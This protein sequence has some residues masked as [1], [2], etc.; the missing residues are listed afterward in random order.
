MLGTIVNSI[1]IILGSLLGIIIKRGIK[2]QYKKIIMDGVGLTVIIIGIMGGVK[3][4]NIIL[5]IISI[6]LGSIIGEIIGIENKLNSL[7]N[8]LE[9]KFGKNDSNF[10]KGFV[11]AS[12]VYCVGAM[13]I[14]GS[15][16]SGLLGNHNT[17]FAKSVLD[18]ISS[19]IFAST[20]GI[21][22][23]FSSIAVFIYQGLITLLA[24]YLKDLLTSEVILEMSAVG[25]ILIMAIG[26]NILEMKKI[27]VGNM[28]PAIFIP[29]M[30]YILVSIFGM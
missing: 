18:G 8:S 13:A 7:G 9:K 1:A 14:V 4:E 6:A 23:A 21:G 5:A 19:I 22:V 25:G 11:T 27:K 10:S 30:Y 28:L 20:L 16:E 26:I 15:L 3:S 12:L 29:L 2:D 17:L 24:T